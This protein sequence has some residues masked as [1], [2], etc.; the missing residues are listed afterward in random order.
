MRKI[1]TAV[2]KSRLE[3]AFAEL[4]RSIRFLDEDRT[5]FSGFRRLLAATWT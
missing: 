5:P 2:C 3:E 1:C 4:D